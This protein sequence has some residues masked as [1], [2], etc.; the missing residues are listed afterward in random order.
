MMPLPLA[1]PAGPPAAPGTPDT[2]HHP[3]GDRHGAP[4]DGD[5]TGLLALLAGVLSPPASPPAIDLVADGA[6]PAAAGAPADGAASPSLDALVS[7]LAQQAVGLPGGPPAATPG[8]ATPPDPARPA[9]AVPDASRALG[10]TT[11]DGIPAP[12][13]PAAGRG[14]DTPFPA[15]SGVTPTGERPDAVPASPVADHATGRS[16]VA[17]LAHQAGVDTA[18]SPVAALAH[19]ASR[20][21]A[22][23]SDDDPGGSGDSNTPISSDLTAALRSVGENGAS[24]PSGES[25]PSAVSSRRPPDGAAGNQTAALHAPGPAPARPTEAVA[26]PVDAPAV[27]TPAAVADQ[28]VSAVVPLHGRGDGR[29]AVTLELRP[30]ELGTIR[31][32]VSV[33]HQTV[34]LTLH[35]A[36]PAT[37]RLLAAALPELRT[38]LT[39]AGLTAGQLGVGGDGGHGAGQRRTAGG[40]GEGDGLADAHRRGGRRPAGADPAGT[41]PIRTF[42]PAAAGRLDLFL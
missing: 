17:D 4:A 9:P 32:E 36:D 19:S 7:A 18:G 10:S 23:P 42:R 20:R 5:F 39:D 12:P 13:P 38:A 14:E 26:A 15:P 3:S 41:G 27:A 40:D 37:G 35:A 21:S 34:H 22:A 6:G 1:P 24:G 30:E 25:G 8:S 11:P 28:V 2:A 31:V 33:E 29:H 16:P